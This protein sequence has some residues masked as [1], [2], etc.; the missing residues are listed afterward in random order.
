MSDVF[1]I[2]FDPAAG[3]TGLSQ[4]AVRLLKTLLERSGAE[5]PADVP[6]KV[7]FGE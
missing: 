6:L 2:P 3:T 4:A 7:H 1:F 5:L